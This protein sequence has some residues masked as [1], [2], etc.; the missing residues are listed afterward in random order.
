MPVCAMSP[1]ARFA[2][3]QYFD[4]RC[5]GALASC[6]TMQPESL[7]LPNLAEDWRFASNPWATGG[8]VGFYAGYNI[9]VDAAPDAGLLAPS[10]IDSVPA[11]EPVGTLCLVSAVPRTAGM[12]LSPAQR[13]S[14]IMLADLAAREIEAL[15]AINRRATEAELLRD[16]AELL[17]RG[18][19][20]PSLPPHDRLSSEGMS[21]SSRSVD[22]DFAASARRAISSLRSHLACEVRSRCWAR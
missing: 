22:E 19:A 17:K 5:V 4:P 13:Q 9:S 1:P 18:F 2:R 7:Q 21:T 10:D 20:D 6:L 15:F 8:I 11:R 16:G 12:E 14:M 3:M